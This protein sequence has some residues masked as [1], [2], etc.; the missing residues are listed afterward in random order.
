MC[1]R[2]RHS[3]LSVLT[4]LEETDS[5]D[6]R[7]K[8]LANILGR[9]KTD[10]NDDLLEVALTKPAT[11]R[12]RRWIDDAPVNPI[13]ALM[14]KSGVDEAL[15]ANI[16]VAASSA[17]ENKMTPRYTSGVIS[18]VINWGILTPLWLMAGIYVSGEIGM[19]E[20]LVCLLYTSPSPRDATLSRMPSSA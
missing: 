2:D 7:V 10:D 16:L 12:S 11:K 17:V 19:L 14:L 1:I 8:A 18:R 5:Y 4:E 6:P 9:P 13:A 15:N 3:A 20:G